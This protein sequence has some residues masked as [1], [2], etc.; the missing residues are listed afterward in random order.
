MAENVVWSLDFSIDWV[1]KGDLTKKAIKK[2]INKNIVN[3][4]KVL[5][6]PSLANEY[7]VNSG[8]R[9]YPNEP[10]AVTMLIA[11]VL[12]DSGKCLPTID[13]GILIA[14]PPRPIPTKSPK[15]IWKKIPVFGPVYKR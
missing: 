14:V 9:K 8:D 4:N 15:L 3:T 6:Q 13:I 7:V 10:T 12:L 5:S 2:P 1:D 11:I